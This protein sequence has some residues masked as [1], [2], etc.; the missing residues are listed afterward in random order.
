MMLI[1]KIAYKN[2]FRKKGRTLLTLIP[3]IA[4]SITL[5]AMASL[6]EGLN[7][8]SRQNIIDY[9]TSHCKI[10][11]S[12]R[13]ISKKTIDLKDSFIPYKDIIAYLDN[14]PY[15]K[16][17]T[18]TITFTGK[19]SDGIN[20][21]PVICIGCDNSSFSK[22]FKTMADVYPAANTISPG[23]VL[24]GEDIVAIFES[25]P[26]DIFILESRTQFGAYDAL[27]LY[28][29]SSIATGNPLI[30][31]NAILINFSDAEKFLDTEGRVT[32]IA[33]LLNNGNDIR[34]FSKDFNDSFRE[35]HK[36]IRMITWQEGEEDFIAFAMAD[37]YS[38]YVTILIIVLI[39]GIGIANTMLLS[40]Y[41]RMREIATMRALG[42]SA[43]TI[44]KIFISEGFFIGLAGVVIGSV[45]GILIMAYI[46]MKGIN[47]SGVFNNMHIGYPLKGIIKGSFNLMI[48]FY[49]SLFTLFISISAA[50]YPAY[51]ATKENIVKIIR[52]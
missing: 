41:E 43:G 35:L 39:A 22:V 17:Y 36:D 34:P 15:V 30:D 29:K 18:K 50:L 5:I 10:V 37:K 32:E 19:L 38:G 28:Y 2:I 21:I 11:H 24:I 46:S 48:V 49:T 12:E 14:S 26:E 4:S 8:Q 52:T 23:D 51:R 45:I 13:D 3:V 25:K 44:L 27:D 7:I 9:Q 1:L 6:T 47:I 42:S 40:I 33:I 20:K 16:A 31:R